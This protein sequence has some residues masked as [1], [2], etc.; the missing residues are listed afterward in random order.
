LSETLRYSCDIP[1]QALAYKLGDIFIMNLRERMRAALG[2]RFEVK[3]FHSVVLR[4]GAL[5]LSDL[6]WHIDR[7]IERLKAVS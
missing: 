7:E 5:P 4:P 2:A 6:S 3:E 1:A